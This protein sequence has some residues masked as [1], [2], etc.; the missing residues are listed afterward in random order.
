[1]QLEKKSLDL[2]SWYNDVQGSLAQ[3][4]LFWSRAVEDRHSPFHTPTIANVGVDGFPRLRTMVLREA[5]PVARLIRFHTDVRSQKAEDIK[6]N[7][8]VAVMGYDAKAKVQIRLEGRASV[9]HHDEISHQA[10]THSKTMS[11]VC[12]GVS[13]ASGSL[14]EAGNAYSLPNT[15]ELLSVSEANFCVVRIHINTLE[16]LYLA[17][18]GHR[19]LRCTYD[20]CGHVQSDWLVP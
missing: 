16:W 3:A 20:E 8:R 6:L 12:Y 4:W 9:H 1:M 15:P 5:D 13:P 17:R 18:E 11:Q 14:I 19:R 7:P 10:W 2:P